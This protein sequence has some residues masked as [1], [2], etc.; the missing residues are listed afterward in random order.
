M[1]IFTLQVRSNISDEQ[2][3]I[4]LTSKKKDSSRSYIALTERIIPSSIEVV[5]NAIINFKDKCN[6]KYKD[7]RKFTSKKFHCKFHNNNLVETFEIKN[8]K[9]DIEKNTDAKSRNLTHENKCST[10]LEHSILGRK[11]Y[12][13]GAFSYYELLQIEEKKCTGRPKEMTISGVMLSDQEVKKFISPA[14]KKESAFN[15]AK[16][17]F[18]LIEQSEKQTKVEYEY[19]ALTDHWLLNKEV[20]VSQVF[21][22]IS[23][24]VN[25]LLNSVI[26]GA[27]HAVQLEKEVV[28]LDQ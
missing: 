15:Q 9:T 8:L 2:R 12:N 1:L 6:N 23:D 14:F 20:S 10:Q 25:D 18:R 17:S 11:A 4:T 7:K 5:K 3:G 28:N 19:N 26:I 21:K 22:S 13:R 27:R 16:W 24:S